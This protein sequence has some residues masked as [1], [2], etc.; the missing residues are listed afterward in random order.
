MTTDNEQLDSITLLDRGQVAKAIGRSPDTL[1]EWVAAGKFPRPIQAIDGGRKQWPLA[2]VKAWIAKR[3]RSR[4]Q[5]RSPR[6]ALKRGS[7]LIR[8]RGGV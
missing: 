3:Q 1:D 6:G 2:Q 5:P 4:Y 8:Q 7:K